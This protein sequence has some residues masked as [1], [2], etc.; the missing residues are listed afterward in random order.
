METYVTSLQETIT[1]RRSQPSHGQRRKTS[2]RCKVWK[3]GSPEGIAAQNGK[4]SM[5]MD[6][7]PKKPFA[8]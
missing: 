7:Q 2:E 6:P 1:Q 4:N 8:A 5:L 3:G